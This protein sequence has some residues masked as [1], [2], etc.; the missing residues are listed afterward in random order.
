M[1]DI[2]LESDDLRDIAE[3]CGKI[4]DESM[5]ILADVEFEIDSAKEDVVMPSMTKRELVDMAHEVS[6]SIR[7]KKA[8]SSFVRR[9]FDSSNA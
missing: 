3:E 7:I 5:S 8:E 4:L 1:L 9:H 6:D 2:V